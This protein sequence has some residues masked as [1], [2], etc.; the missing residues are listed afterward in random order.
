ML[1]RSGSTFCIIGLVCGCCFFTCFR[2]HCEI[3]FLAK[4]H[5]VKCGVAVAPKRSN[6]DIRE[7]FKASAAPKNKQ[8]RSE[9]TVAVGPREVVE[10]SD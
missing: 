5:Y 4:A 1:F 10:L 6:C 9:S 3:L 7:M 8:Q 2:P